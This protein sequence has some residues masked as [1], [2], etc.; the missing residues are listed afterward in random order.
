M[1]ALRHF[2]FA[3]A[4]LG[5][6]SA[7]GAIVGVKD[8][9]VTG[10]GIEPQGGS[11]AGLDVEL[12]PEASTF[13]AD[14][15]IVVQPPVDSGCAAT[16]FG[17]FEPNDA[18]FEDQSTTKMN[19][20]NEWQ[21]ARGDNNDPFTLASL[22]YTSGGTV[23]RAVKFQGFQPG[24][25][26]NKRDVGIEVSLKAKSSRASFFKDHDLRVKLNA[27]GTVTSG[28]HRNE[29]PWPTDYEKR[30]YGGPS[31]LWELEKSLSPAAVNGVDFGVV[32][33]L[34]KPNNDGLP[35]FYLDQVTV[36]IYTCD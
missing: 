36:T 7:C 16:A 17:T 21:R 8:L 35:D 22:A 28:N 2:L 14:D 12:L 19:W 10:D 18:R 26:D 6:V 5:A 3:S 20:V 32:Y 27:D 15:G 34:E 25:P 23:S 9:T 1:K 11:D 24:V 29:T 31:T 30:T 13:E 33:I 4:L